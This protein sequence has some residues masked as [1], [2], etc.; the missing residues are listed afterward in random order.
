MTFF[1]L[2]HS[3]FVGPLTWK[4][5]AQILESRK[6]RVIIPELSDDKTDS[7]FWEQHARSAANAINELDIHAP[8]V[9]VGHSGAGPLLPNISTLLK[10]PVAGYIFVDAGIPQPLNRLDMIRVELPERA[11]ELEQFL[12][13][14]GRYPRWSD[15]DLQNLIPNEIL[16]QQMLKEIT[17]RALPFFTESLPVP[18]EWDTIPCGY[19]QFSKGYKVSAEQARK[20]GWPVIEFQAG[21]FHMLVEP[22]SAANALVEMT[23]ELGI[24]M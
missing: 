8:C 2:I 6:H 18:E 14:G 13:T 5:V 15:A 20:K 16:R 1:A 21:H 3:P 7:P 17:P 23:L 10:D 24:S 4:L 9:L 19:I 11:D 12:K 22:A